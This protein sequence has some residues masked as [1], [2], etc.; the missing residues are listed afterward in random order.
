MKISDLDNTIEIVDFENMFNIY[1]DKKTKSY[2]YNLNESLYINID[3]NQC[4]K[5][6]L[7]TDAFWPLI[8]YKLYDT[9]KLYWLLMKINR[10]SGKDIFSK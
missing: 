8:S 6:K 1:E 10:I 7:T 4:E 2:K 9:T 5:Y 3:L